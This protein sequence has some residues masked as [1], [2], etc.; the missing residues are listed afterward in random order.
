MDYLTRDKLI[1]R[2]ISKMKERDIPQINSVHVSFEPAKDIHSIYDWLIVTFYNF[3]P[4]RSNAY[5]WMGRAKVRINGQIED[6]GDFITHQQI[7]SIEEYT[8]VPGGVNWYEED[9]IWYR[10]EN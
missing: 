3:N 2:A 10:Y 4:Q 6:V 5:Q 1:E 7:P 9:G 8:S